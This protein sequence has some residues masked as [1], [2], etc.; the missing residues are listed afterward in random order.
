MAYRDGT[1]KPHCGLRFKTEYVHRYDMK[2][3][4]PCSK[5][6]TLVKFLQ[7]FEKRF[8]NGPNGLRLKQDK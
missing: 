4:E 5:P 7:D 3:A 8:E 2:L 6:M 1:T